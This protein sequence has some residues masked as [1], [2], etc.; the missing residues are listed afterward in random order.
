MKHIFIV[1]PAAGKDRA[2][3]FFLPL[4][5]KTSKKMGIEYEIHRTFGVGDAERF[6]RG[7]CEERKGNPRDRE[8]ILRFYACGGDGTLNE[9]ANGAYGY[10]NVEIAMIP[11]GTGNDFPRNFNDYQVFTDIERQING[12]A[13]PVDLIRYESLEKTGPE[14]E[15]VKY[16]MN[17]FNIGLDCNVVDKAAE[18]RKY[19]L[20]PRQFAYG[21]SIGIL[22][23]RKEGAD[24]DIEFD[25]G[26]VHSGEILLTAI[27]NGCY[28][29]GGY[30]GVPYADLF[31]GMMDVSIVESVTRRTFLSLLG[32]YK[33]GT[34]LEDPKTEQIVT[35]KKCKSLVI[36]PRNQMKLC[37][38]GEIILRG[39]TQFTIISKAINFSIPQGCE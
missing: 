21:L 22:L 32:K 20:I 12:K 29:G 5:M 25:D 24:L 36:R 17:M 16:C 18:L 11:A 2:E 27:A 3:K 37:V 14:E 6:V 10:P 8:D 39:D 1:N 26:T 28:C 31:D 7:R 4:I 35:Y 9:A 13:Q 38:D 34:H 30:K 23:G 33:K 19:P 15:P